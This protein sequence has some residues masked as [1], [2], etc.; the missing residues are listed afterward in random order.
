VTVDRDDTLER[1]SQIRLITKNYA[2]AIVVLALLVVVNFLVARGANLIETARVDISLLVGRQSQLVAG[3]QSSTRA[4]VRNADDPTVTQAQHEKMRHRLA[5]VLDDLEAV[6]ASLREVLDR[7]SWLVGHHVPDSVRSIFDGKPYDL[8]HWVD[9]TVDRARILT[10]LSRRDVE[11]R[12]TDWSLTDIALSSGTFIQQ[13]YQQAASELQA[14]SV[15]TA[16]AVGTVQV[17]LT[18]TTLAL[19]GG[20]VLFV[21]GPMIRRIRRENVRG[22]EARRRIEHLAYN[23]L[24]T[25]VA[26][27]TRFSGLVAEAAR[28]RL[29]GRPFALAVLDLDGFKAT[30]DAFGHGAGDDLIVEVSRRIQAVLTE[31]DVLARLGGDEFAVY[32]PG[33]AD[34]DELKR[35]LWRIRQAVCRPWTTA[36]IPVDVRASA[37]GALFPH[38]SDEPDRLFAYA[39]RALYAAKSAPSGVVVFDPELRRRSD[40]ETGLLRDLPAAFARGEFVLHFQPQ[41]RVADGGLAGVEALVRW[42]HP[43]LGLIHPGDFLPAVE[44]A[45]RIV[46]LTRVVLDRALADLAAWQAANLPVDRVAVNMPEAL[47]SS[48]IGFR[49]VREALQAHWLPG[50]ALTIEITEDVFL[51]RA[52]DTVQQVAQATADL[53]VRIAFDDFGTGYASLTHLRTFRFDELKIDRSFVAEIGGASMSEK[54]VHSLAA[55]ARALGKDIVAEGVETEDQYQFLRTQ[56]C[57]CVQG[58]LF[59]RP[60]PAADLAAW[61]RARYAG[62]RPAETETVGAG[63]DPGLILAAS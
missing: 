8:L 58:Y 37:G 61:V 11:R 35:A 56:G 63:P 50:S 38:H 21:F 36:G 24:L 33:I 27:R 17:A 16:R 9:T 62:P 29:D 5:G 53:G 45:G 4:I 12:R 26:N 39:D 1:D 48:D 43:D 2:G 20:E 52:A 7:K 47:L 44:R 30:N 51:S 18:V 10:I 54:I 28:L 15:R 55:L 14:A 6:N 40:E 22:E 57:T 46:D 41:I 49:I 32:L 31:H 42:Q 60:M 59:A 19:L 3:V 13:G 23:D 25:G 34:P